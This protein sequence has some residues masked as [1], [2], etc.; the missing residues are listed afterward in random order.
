MNM[1]KKRKKDK[2]R[3]IIIICIL[4]FCLI[5]GFIV[6]VVITDRQLTIFEKTIKDSVLTVQ[7]IIAYP[8]DFILNK[9]EENKEKN[10]MYEEYQL[11]KEENLANEHYKIE[12][13]ELKKEINEMKELLNINHTLAEYTKLSATVI[14]RNLG[15][16]YDTITINKGEHDG[17]VIGMPAVVG[18]G[19]IGK[20]IST[21][22]FNSTIR[23]ITA[24]D[25][26][27]KISVK[28][29]LDENNYVYGILSNYDS[30]TK[31]H[32]I[33][34]ISET[35]EIK[36]G[37]LVTTTGMGNIFPAGILIGKITGVRTDTFDL[38]NVLEMQSDGNFEEI[39]YV[40]LLKRNAW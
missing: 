17:V 35:S 40:T 3:K 24:T 23:L 33:E 31:T 11:L 27:D 8:F 10:K 6:N 28:I 9:I 14:D 38:S 2:K 13:E 5:T 4:V 30:E 29:Q 32:I 19:L 25:V 20:V 26:I 12:N 7:K 1:Y 37:S 34:G 39:N 15:Y 36:N 22:T 21:T 16:W 18:N